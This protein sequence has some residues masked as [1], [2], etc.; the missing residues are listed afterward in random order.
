MARR[1]TRLPFYTFDSTWWYYSAQLEQPARFASKHAHPARLKNQSNLVIL[2]KKALSIGIFSLAVFTATSGVQAQTGSNTSVRAVEKSSEPNESSAT[3]ATNRA[4][5]AVSPSSEKPSAATRE[6]S[7][8]PASV[9]PV[10]PAVASA[11]VNKTSM[12]LS[13]VT[14]QPR[15]SL[16]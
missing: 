1:N 10:D 12:I 11:P 3:A 4:V 9:V 14:L 6:S 15:T 8:A 16:R 2:M 5:P 13:P 7:S